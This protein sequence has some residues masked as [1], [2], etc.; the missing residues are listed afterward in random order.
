MEILIS[1]AIILSSLVATVF[2]KTNVTTWSEG[3]VTLRFVI[4]DMWFVT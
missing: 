3:Y 1:Q 4:Y 2:V